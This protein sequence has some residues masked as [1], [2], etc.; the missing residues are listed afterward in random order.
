MAGVALFQLVPAIMQG[1][2]AAA[3]IWAALVWLIVI[4]QLA[5]A[6]WLACVPDWSTVWIG[7][8]VAAVVA[9]FYALALALVLV[10]PATSVVW[11]DLDEVRDSARL[12]CGA[13]VLLV[14]LLAYACSRVAYEWRKA[15]FAVA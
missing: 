12:W 6:A 9:A 7:M 8:I 13:V 3:P 10:T 4:A 15:F 14:F 5:Y 2:P 11:F 1:S